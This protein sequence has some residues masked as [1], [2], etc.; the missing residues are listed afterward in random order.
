MKALSRVTFCW[1]LFFI[2]LAASS[3]TGYADIVNGGFE[4]GQ[5][6]FDGWSGSGSNF[7]I[8]SSHAS[9]GSRSALI[10]IDARACE[11]ATL[12][13]EFSANAGQSLSFDCL[14]Q[15]LWVIDPPNTAA[16]ASLVVTV[17]GPDFFGL[18]SA[19][20]F[21]QGEWATN[22]FP[23]FPSTGDYTVSIEARAD[24]HILDPSQG[25]QF[26]LVRIQANFDNV[27]LVP[28]PSTFVLIGI[29]AMGVLFRVWGRRRLSLSSCPA[30]SFYVRCLDR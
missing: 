5:F 13:Q 27:Q 8:D 4:S 16:S 19:D 12:V 15:Q 30:R 26:P 22:T 6:Y 20:G 17:V 29:G 14:L 2:V 24:A 28:E 1:G 18:W 7:Y 10:D 23:A 3:R 25:T 21:P 11:D 9:E